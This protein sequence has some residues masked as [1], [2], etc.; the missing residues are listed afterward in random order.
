MAKDFVV[1]VDAPKLKGSNILFNEAGEVR[2]EIQFSLEDSGVVVERGVYV[3]WEV[4]P[5]E[6][7]DLNGDPIPHPPEYKQMPATVATQLKAMEAKAIQDIESDYG[8]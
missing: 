2:A 3:Y 1:S 8:F 6:L 4:M 5:P 7:L